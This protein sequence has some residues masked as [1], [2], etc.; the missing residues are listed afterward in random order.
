MLDRILALDT[1]RFGILMALG[2]ILSIHGLWFLSTVMRA[3]RS[4]RR[5]RNKFHNSV[6]IS[7]NPYEPPQN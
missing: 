3:R 4:R 7:S 6:R 1:D 2:F 5:L